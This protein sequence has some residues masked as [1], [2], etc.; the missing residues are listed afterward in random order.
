MPSRFRP[1]GVNSN[2]H[3]TIRAG[4]KPT[5]STATTA[6]ITQA[7][8]SNTGSRVAATCV[9]SHAPTR[10]SPAMR[11]TL[12]RLSSLMNFI[13]WPASADGSGG[14]SDAG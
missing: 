14:R 10:Y 11:M 4:T 13:A 6:F 8:A 1:S 7:G 2:A 3:A 9:T 12:R 5:A